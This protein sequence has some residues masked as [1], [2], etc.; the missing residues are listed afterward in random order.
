M[1]KIIIIMISLTFITG[2]G[3]EKNNQKS[4]SVKESNSNS[5]VV[6]SNSNSNISKS[7]LDKVNEVIN[8]SNYNKKD[9]IDLDVK[10]YKFTYTKYITD[11]SQELATILVKKDNVDIWGYVTEKN[12]VGQNPNNEFLGIVSDKIFIQNNWNLIVFD[13]NSGDIINTIEKFGY[14]GEKIYEN[15]TYIVFASSTYTHVVDSATDIFILN[16]SDCSVKKIISAKENVD[17]QT[18]TGNKILLS[19]NLN[20]ETGKSEKEYEIDIL[21]L[22]KD[23]F[24]NEL[25]DIK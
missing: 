5:N 3:K 25:V 14:G 16:K 19:K 13:L 20:Y 12:H 10:E 9:N 17:I 21:E 11:E 15:D 2:C 8:N 24:S 4:N 18:K 7:N 22:L 1:K 23:N 6:E